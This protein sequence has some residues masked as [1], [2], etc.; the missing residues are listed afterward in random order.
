MVYGLDTRSYNRSTERRA[1][2][3]MVEDIREHSE[4]STWAK[5]A[6]GG[7]QLSFTGALAHSS[8]LQRFRVFG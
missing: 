8:A 5:E 7:L 3:K 6:E 4:S 1:N 2:Q